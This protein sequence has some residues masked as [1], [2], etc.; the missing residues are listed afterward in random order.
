MF[1]PPEAIDTCKYA[2]AHCPSWEDRV[3]YIGGSLFIAGFTYWLGKHQKNQD[4]QF[5]FYNDTVIAPSATDLNTFVERYRDRL[6]E[7]GKRNALASGGIAVPRALSKLH[8]EFSQD[9]YSLKDTIVARLE[10]FDPK[11]V[12]KLAGVIDELD[13]NITSWLF[14]KRA[15]GPKE[16]DA[17][18]DLLIVAKRSMTRIIYKGKLSI[19]K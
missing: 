14:S 3:I 12:A 7:F 5:S 9:L 18:T 13:N 19:L 6:R 2:I 15:K 10:V 16:Q 8:T 17:M 1:V 11:A 4:R